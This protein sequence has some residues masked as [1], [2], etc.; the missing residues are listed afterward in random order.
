MIQ[1]LSLV[2]CV[3]NSSW[4]FSLSLVVLFLFL[5]F[6][7]FFI[8]CYELILMNFFVWLRPLLAFS[9]IRN[10]N[11]IFTWFFSLFDLRWVY[12]YIVMIFFSLWRIFVTWYFWSSIEIFIILKTDMIIIKTELML[13][14]WL[15]FSLIFWKITSLK[16]LWLSIQGIS[17]WKPIVIK[18]FEYPRP[19]LYIIFVCVCFLLAFVSTFGFTWIVIN[20]M[21]THF[22]CFTI[23]YP[24]LHL[25]LEWG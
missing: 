17:T 18:T 22:A 4:Y 14:Y 16:H 3:I 19:D 10:R 6:K 24:I 5:D 7:L 12:R 15:L 11:E 25:C 1:F 21:L 9:L 2:C 20:F 23:E 8:I 13:L